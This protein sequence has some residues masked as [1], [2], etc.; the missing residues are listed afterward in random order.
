MNK[1]SFAVAAALA[2]SA[3]GSAS[4]ADGTINFT[5]RIVAATCTIDYGT[6]GSTINLSHISSSALADSADAG[7]RPVNITLK[8]GGSGSSATCSKDNANLLISSGTKTTT[9]GLLANTH[10]DA[11]TIA[12]GLVRT[13]DGSNA[14]I[15]L[16]DPKDSLVATKTAGEFKYAFTAKY[17]T[18]HGA[19]TFKEGDYTG[20]LMFDIDNY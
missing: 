7:S 10:A 15:N 20:Q 8:A 16:A 13:D 4:A 9:D 6:T 14:L 12:V 3:A 11:A 17:H 2:M 19:G 1:I 18:T 5:G